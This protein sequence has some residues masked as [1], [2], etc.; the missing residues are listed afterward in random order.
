M[1][2]RLVT[3]ARRWLFTSVTALTLASCAFGPQPADDGPPRFTVHLNVIDERGALLADASVELIDTH[4]TRQSSHHRADDRG[5]VRLEL[6]SPAVVVVTAPGRIDEPV[7][8]GPHDNGLTVALWDREGA[9]GRQRVSMHFGGD[10][11][12][13]RRYLDPDRRT[14]WVG[15]DTGARRLVRHLAPLSE[16]ADWTVVNLETV[17]GD[18]PDDSALAGKRF[19]LRSEPFAVDALDEL[20]V[21]VVALGNNHVYDWGPDGLAVTLELLDEAGIGHVGAGPTR[22]EAVRGRL[23]E[24]GGLTVGT[25]SVTTVNGDAINDRL[26]DGADPIPA[27]LPEADAWQY[28]LRRFGYSRH[29]VTIPFAERRIGDAWRVF[30]DYEPDLDADAAAELWTA[31][32]DVYPELQDWVARRGHGG[33]APYSADEVEAEI[34]RL[35]AEGA[36]FVVFQ[37]H[38]GFEFAEVASTFVRRA[39]HR[40]IDAGAD[41]VVGHHPHVLQ[42]VEW[43]GDGLIV[44]SLGNLVFDQDI[45]PTFASA[46]LRVVTDG[47]EI[48]EARILPVF[49]D[50]Y[51]PKPA[52]GQSAALIVRM[53]EQRTAAHAV[54]QRLPDGRVGTV[55]TDLDRAETSIRRHGNAGLV[56]RGR[57]VAEWS[58]QMVA[59]EVVEL[60]DCTL[61]RSDLL[62]PGV[63]IGTD[64][65]GWGHFDRDT[66]SGIARSGDGPD[67]QL[68]L[69]WRVPGD[70]ARWST[71]PGSSGSMTD[72][73][74]SLVTDPN[75]PTTVRLIANVDLAR[76]RLF[77]DDGTP[78]D[79]RPEL[80]V[81]LS[82][83]RDRGE[84]PALR[85]VTF[86][87]DST[88]TPITQ[89]LTGVELPLDVPDDG[90]WHEVTVELPD[91]LLDPD[92]SGRTANKANLLIDAPP[93]IFG[94]LDL[95]DVRIV[96]WRR[97]TRSEI[98][99]WIAADFVRSETDGEIDL[100][101]SRC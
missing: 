93:A 74:F 86:E 91:G 81:R 47:D 8:V 48:L 90:R 101:V 7:V 27:D 39:A 95:D 98:P 10:V 60:P 71:A 61:V 66:V 80:E 38:G 77:D 1:T 51:R 69:G 96:E 20:G 2:P 19:L 28:E 14:A 31:L 23:D 34:T 42:G 15:S 79:A 59:G 29:G 99:A 100:T 53:I 25:I 13:G 3:S 40:A 94:T 75:R 22:D 17:V 30:A 76:H 6:S 57:T 87:F 55:T 26:P 11:M 85:F 62:L 41:L 73:A 64:Q 49:L 63:E 84:Q 97:R 82:A 56:E 50:R 32:S 72:R 37:L 35:R 58:A 78:V 67:R 44:H 45:L 88:S 54:S 9:D 33:A 5:L 92:E 89:R 36:E 12:L 46:V 68:P 83:R 52:T 70:P 43:Y 18:L 16:R 24:V 65:F 4:G 21:D